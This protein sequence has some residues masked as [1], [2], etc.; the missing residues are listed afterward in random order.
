MSARKHA[1]IDAYGIERQDD[2]QDVAVGYQPPPALPVEPAVAPV[3]ARMYRFDSPA[4]RTR[5]RGPHFDV[6]KVK[7]E[8]VVPPVA[9]NVI[10]VD[11]GWGSESIIVTTMLPSVPEPRTGNLAPATAPIEVPPAATAPAIAPPISTPPATVPVASA[12]P[13]SAATNVP[14]IAAAETREPATVPAPPPPSSVTKQ[15]EVAAESLLSRPFIPAWEVDRLDWPREVEQLF[16]TQRDY[17]GYAG[18]KLLEAS[19]E[20]LQVL[21]LTS[22]QPGEGVTTLALCLARTAADAGLNVGLLDLNLQRPTVSTRLGLRFACDWQSTAAGKSPLSEAAIKSL[23]DGLT[24]LP[25]YQHGEAVVQSL[26]D[27][28]VAKLIREAATGC[29]LLILDAGQ[30]SL[31]EIASLIDAV[32]VVRDVRMT[33]EQQTLSVATQMKRCGV[34]AVG[35]A[36]NFGESQTQRAAA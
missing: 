31:S 6:S 34:Q 7:A 29:E 13:V 32:M 1:F 30:E 33:T 8:P 2:D 26:G 20:G 18:K 16:A 19:R 5:L 27:E 11:A 23:Q 21:A 36:E 25:L 4:Q 3:A 22:A 28:T 14:A 24:V 10:E 9:A 35:I 15:P 17:F 12:P